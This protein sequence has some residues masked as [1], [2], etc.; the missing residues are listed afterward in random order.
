MLPIVEAG[1]PHLPLVE[2]EAEGADEVEGGAGGEA[3]AA[4]VSR[5]PVNFRLHQDY[6]KGHGAL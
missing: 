5:V 3:G 2:G 4:G 1:P 6:M